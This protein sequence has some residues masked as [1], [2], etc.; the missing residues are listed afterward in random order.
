MDW[1]VILSPVLLLP[2]VLLFRFIGCHLI[3]DTDRHIADRFRVDYVVR[4]PRVPAIPR[5]DVSIVLFHEHTA[6]H[7]SDP[8]RT[9]ML[10]QD[11]T[12][13][14]PEGMEFVFRQPRTLDELQK[15]LYAAWSD[16]FEA[17]GR[18]GDVR[19]TLPLIREWWKRKPE[20]IEVTH[21]SWLN[22]NYGAAAAKW[23][24]ALSGETREYLRA[25]A[26]FIEEGRLPGA[27]D[28]LPDV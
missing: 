26:F 28:T 3:I 23:R 16:P 6:L 19:W 14:D 20:M 9:V 5:Y 8:T 18:D 10:E 2:I 17:Y 11:M 22:Q 21:Y 25:Y 7:S 15:V 4:F 27:T 12:Y 1:Y 13:V 24:D